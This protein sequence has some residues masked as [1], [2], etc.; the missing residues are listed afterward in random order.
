MDN[1]ITI[2]VSDNGKGINNEKLQIIKASLKNHINNINDSIGIINVNERIK[3]TY[4]DNFGVEID[5]IE[6]VGT[7]VH[8]KI[9][10]ISV[11]D[12]SNN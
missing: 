8:I 11:C 5:S 12:I 2:T 6:G 7:N 9:P 3:L 1:K 10:A 4:G